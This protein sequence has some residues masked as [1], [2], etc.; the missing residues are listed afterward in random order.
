MVETLFG[1]FSGSDDDRLV[2]C[3]FL[4]ILT[5]NLRFRFEIFN[6]FYKK[7]LHK[8]ERKSALRFFPTLL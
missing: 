1:P 8:A 5:F 4:Y 6:N 2:F 3:F 7:R